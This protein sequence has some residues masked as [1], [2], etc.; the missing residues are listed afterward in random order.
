[1]AGGGA[2]FALKGHMSQIARDQNP[3]G[4]YGMNILDR[5]IQNCR[6]VIPAPT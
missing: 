2:E 1:L 3:I 4:T 5:R 6:I